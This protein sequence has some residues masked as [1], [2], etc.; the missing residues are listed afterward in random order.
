MDL[1][2]LGI[3]PGQ[4]DWYVAITRGGLIP[5]CLLAQITGQRRIDTICLASYGKDNKQGT[6]QILDQ[7]SY[8]HFTGKRVLIIDDL[9]DSGETMQEAVDRLRF[10]GPS[11]LKTMVIYKKSCSAF[12]PD[13]F[14]EEVS[15]DRWIEFWWEPTE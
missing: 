3:K 4:F 1:R 5:A 6:L 10:Y 8:L 11:E 7:R 15:A 13:Y 2:K 12:H 14:L 9:V